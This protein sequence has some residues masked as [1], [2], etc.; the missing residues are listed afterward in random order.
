MPMEIIDLYSGE[1]QR[2]EAEE[3]LKAIQTFAIGTGNMKKEHSQ[4]IQNEL[5]RAISGGEKKIVKVSP[6][7]LAEMGLSMQKVKRG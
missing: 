7:D 5:K 1:M 4:S 6:E 3:R 2:L